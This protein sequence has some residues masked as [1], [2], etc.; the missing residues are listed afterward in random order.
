MHLNCNIKL[1]TGI[2][3]LMAAMLSSAI[4]KIIDLNIGLEVALT[5]LCSKLTGWQSYLQRHDSF[6]G[7]SEAD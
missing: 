6:C 7:L 1:L 5:S 2:Y 4:I 3:V